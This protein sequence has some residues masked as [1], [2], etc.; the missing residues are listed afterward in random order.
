MIFFD[1]VT[2]IYQNSK[3]LALNDINL[4]IERGEFATLVGQSGAGKSTL[5]KLLIVEEMPTQGEIYFDKLMISRINKAAL[6][7]L[8]R[9][10]GMVF[11]DFR[12]I[13]NKTIFENIAFVPE[14]MGKSEADIINSVIMAMDIVGIKEKSNAFPRQ[15]SGGEQQRVAIA[16]AI[17]HHPLILIA[18]EPTGN[19]DLL[20][21]WE[22]VKLLTK[23]NELGT[24]VILATHNREI[25]NSLNKR[26]ITLDKGRI[27]QDQMTNGRYII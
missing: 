7:T 15:L 25:V 16:R 10:I 6:P 1:K 26:V 17:V 12:L 2:K 3:N 5:L 27:V 18:D 13:P 21:G 4:K 23:I 19:L 9:N 14:V 11:Q 8:R 22:I 24:T 20:N